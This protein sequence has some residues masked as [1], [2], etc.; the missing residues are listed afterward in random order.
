[1]RFNQEILRKS[2]T[3]FAEFDLYWKKKNAGNAEKRA[4]VEENSISCGVRFEQGEGKKDER[5]ELARI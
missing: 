1:M 5:Q 2:L 3:S 4:N